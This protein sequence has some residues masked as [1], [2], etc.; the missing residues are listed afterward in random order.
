MIQLKIAF[1]DEEE[2]Y[3]KQLNGYLVRKKEVFFK[4]WTFSNQEA[5][6]TVKDT[7]EFD[8]VVMTYPFFVLFEGNMPETKKILLHEGDREF[9]ADSCAWVYKYQSA[10]KLFAQ[11]SALLWQE[12]VE[13]KAHVTEKLTELI[14]IYSPVSYEGQMFFGMTLAQILSE[15]K[16]VLYVNLME[17][18]GF[19]QLT[20]TEVFE[21]VGDLFYGMMQQEHDFGTSLHRVR[22]S[23][24][25]FDYIPPA[26][27][28]E[29]LS[30]ISKPLFEEFLMSLRNCSGYDVVIIDFGT[31]F[32]GF[33]EMLPVFSTVYCLG[34]EGVVNRYRMEEFMDYLEKESTYSKTHIQNLLLSE[35]L[36]YPEDVNPL[37]SSLYGGMGDY[38]RECLHGGMEIGG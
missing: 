1:L 2:E 12:D 27:N 34:K 18:S 6:L 37:E 7:V 31:V 19:Y 26:A 3:L 20:K 16:K 9:L 30:E 13:I 38:I 33:A 17:H 22:Q 28:P 32:L 36:L 5:F 14:G 21:D 35:R 8:A 25:D 23:Y 11:I 10:E 29:H 15:Q 4:V 24:R